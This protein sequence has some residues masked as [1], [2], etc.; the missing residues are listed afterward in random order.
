MFCFV[1]TEE[2]IKSA[3]SY[4]LVREE[5][6]IELQMLQDVLIALSELSAEVFQFGFVSALYLK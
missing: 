3:A 6:S 4:T 2:G 5:S 1:L